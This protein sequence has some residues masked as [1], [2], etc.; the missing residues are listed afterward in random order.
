MERKCKLVSHS[1]IL[2]GITVGENSVVGACS[3]VNSDIPA[4]VV[5]AGIPAKVIKQVDSVEEKGKD[6]W[7]MRESTQMAGTRRGEDESEGKNTCCC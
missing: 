6:K 2:P 4:N 3:F 5:A 1:V 7:E